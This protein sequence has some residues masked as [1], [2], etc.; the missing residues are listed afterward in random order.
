[1]GIEIDPTAGE[2]TQRISDAILETPAAIVQL[3]IQASQ[4]RPSLRG[5]Q[6]AKP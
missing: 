2:E 6:C 5:S 3:A 4:S 1:M